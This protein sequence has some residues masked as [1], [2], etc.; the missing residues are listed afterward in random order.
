[1]TTDN[2]MDSDEGSKQ[3]K[4]SSSVAN[5]GDVLPPSRV[6]CSLLHAPKGNGFLCSY[7][8]IFLPII[9][10]LLWT[11]FLFVGS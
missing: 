5:D 11:I 2:N 7:H 3:K 4:T 1:M 10:I 9:S 6:R 8:L